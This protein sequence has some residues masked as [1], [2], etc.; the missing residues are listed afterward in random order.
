MGWQK[1]ISGNRDK[2]REICQQFGVRRLYAFG[3]V[4]TEQFDD[5]RSDVDLIV[6]LTEMPPLARGET[7]LAL[8]EELEKLFQRKV[9]LLTDQPVRNPYLR[10]SIE[11]TKQLIYEGEGQKISF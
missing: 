10:A 2:L 6:E 3:S 11:K 4:I 5:A 9:D 8:W 7:L 1:V